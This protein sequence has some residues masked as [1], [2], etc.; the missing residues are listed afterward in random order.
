VEGDERKV[1]TMSGNVEI[2]MTQRGYEVVSAR[3]TTTFSELDE[4]VQFA[5]VHLQRAHDIRELS[6]RVG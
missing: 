2:K 1:E 5:R 4:A 3:G 6:A